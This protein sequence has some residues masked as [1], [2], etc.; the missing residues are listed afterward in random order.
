MPRRKNIDWKLNCLKSWYG[1]Q[2]QE[3]ASPTV[4]PLNIYSES[5]L[6]RSCRSRDEPAGLTWLKSENQAIRLVAIEA[7][8]KANAG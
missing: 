6:S 4:N 1:V 5:K 3:E 2:G 8:A 7:L